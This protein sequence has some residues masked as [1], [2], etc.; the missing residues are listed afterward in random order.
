M[1]EKKRKTQVTGERREI[2]KDEK[3]KQE[4]YGCC[5]DMVEAVTVC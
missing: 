3:L 1:N 4:K 2:Q 5:T